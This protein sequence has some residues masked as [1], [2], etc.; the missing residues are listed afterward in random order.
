VDLRPF[1]PAAA[2]WQAIGA[3][4]LLERASATVYFTRTSS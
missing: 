1:A 4:L 3:G 2:S